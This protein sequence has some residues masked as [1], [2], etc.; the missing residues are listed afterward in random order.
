MASELG[1]SDRTIVQIVKSLVLVGVFCQYFYNFA[2]V[3]FS[4]CFNCV[5]KLMRL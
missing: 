4:A 1:Q 3:V 2:T 5:F